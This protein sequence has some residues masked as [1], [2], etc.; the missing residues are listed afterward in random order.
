MQQQSPSN[1]QFLPICLPGEGSGPSPCFGAS[2]LSQKVADAEEQQQTP[3]S[4]A[5]RRLSVPYLAGLTENRPR[6]FWQPSMKQTAT[7]SGSVSTYFSASKPSK[8]RAGGIF[9]AACGRSE[10]QL[11]CRSGW[12][13]TIL[14]GSDGGE[15]LCFLDH[16]CQ[17]CRFTSVYLSNIPAVNHL[18]ADMYFEN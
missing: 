3:E 16:I 10:R 11:R 14:L 4:A 17:P 12:Y 6:I 9:P 13:Q 2:Q 18:P 8:L 1:I 7:F 15:V 5:P